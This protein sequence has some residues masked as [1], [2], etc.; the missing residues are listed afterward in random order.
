MGKTYNTIFGY[1][2]DRQRKIQEARYEKVA[3]KIHSSI[4]HKVSPVGTPIVNGIV[5]GGKRFDKKANPP[6]GRFAAKIYMSGSKRR[7]IYI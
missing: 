3:S 7:T 5:A 6:V 2:N 4:D 1:K